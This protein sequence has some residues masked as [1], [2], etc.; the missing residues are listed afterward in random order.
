MRE[1]NKKVSK[2]YMLKLIK[3]F[4]I[5]TLLFIGIITFSFEYGCASQT[6]PK[7]NREMIYGYWIATIK[8]DT[9]SDKYIDDKYYYTI[10][11]YEN[12]IDSLPLT[13]KFKNREFTIFI[14]HK[15]ISKY[16]IKLLTKDSLILRRIEDNKIATYYK[17]K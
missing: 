6:K 11:Q 12:K 7:L 8:S 15:S 10:L 17:K 4:R 3:N 5:F 1:N 16:E 14:K 2:T 9:T 13:Y